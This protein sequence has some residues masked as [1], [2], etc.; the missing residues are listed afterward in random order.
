MQTIKKV[1]SGAIGLF[2]TGA[3]LMGPALA[4]ADLSDFQNMGPSDT[5]IVVGA[6]AATADVVGGINIGGKLAQ[7][8]IESATCSVSCADG[9]TAQVTDGVKIETSSKKLR[10]KGG[11][12]YATL[13]AVRDKLSSNDLD[14]LT[15]TTVT[16]ADGT[17]TTLNQVLDLG[18]KTY[19]TFGEDDPEGSVD[20]PRLILKTDANEP[21][22]EL[23]LTSP[24]GLETKS[25]DNDGPGLAGQDIV[26]AGKTFTVSGSEAD[27]TS[28][29]L[30]LYGGGE[31]KTLVAAGDAISFELDGETHTIRMTSWTGTG[32]IKGVFELDGVSY[33]KGA[34]TAITVDPVTKSKV[35]IKKVEEVKVPSIA[36]GAATEG[37]QATIFVGSSE[38]VIDGTSAPGSVK[39]GDSTISGAEVAFVNSSATKI[40]KIVV[41]YKPDEYKV[42]EAGGVI[43]DPVFGVFD[44]AFAGVSPDLQSD[45]KDKI[46]VEK[47]SNKVRLSFTNRA[48]NSISQDMYLYEG[49]NTWAVK[50][51]SSRVIEYIENP[52]V[53]KTDYF[54]VSDGEYSHVL[55][56]T[57]ID[58]DKDILTIKDIASGDS[59]EVGFTGA[60]GDLYL[61][62]TSYALSGI[63]ESTPYSFVVDD[64][65]IDTC[66]MRTG[67]SV[68][69]FT[70][71]GARIELNDTTVEPAVFI[72]EA[73]DLTDTDKLNLTIYA[74][75]KSTGTDIEDVDVLDKS[76]LIG[77]GMSNVADGKVYHGLTIYGSLV[78][79]DTDADKVTLYYP[80]EQTYANVYVMKAGVSPPTT[81]TT[82]TEVTQTVEVEAPSLGNGIAKLDS[83]VTSVDKEEKNLILVGGPVVNNLVAELAAAQ[84]TPD[85]A[86]WRSDLVGKY[87]LQSVEDAF[88]T[89]KTAIVVAGYEAAD[90]QAASLK[91]A[92]EDVSGAAISCMGT[93]CSDFVY[94]AAEEEAPA[95][96]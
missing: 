69:M 61:G 44:F 86:Y 93:T 94:P 8:G 66:T 68:P 4:A 78:V 45:A 92:T 26:I 70:K 16:Y 37:A 73:D 53:N 13:D 28:T 59:I 18:D 79:S 64:A 46:V 60:T 31:E 77:G 75:Q 14:L 33:T 84:K 12:K 40:S 36:G 50:A 80:D 22:Y 10:L 25:E 20:S 27:I 76:G 30:T 32:T 57:S 62:S 42:A 74:Q 82:G 96:E 49:S 65:C 83:A 11:S 85:T 7:S 34:N 9:G 24:T 39:V 51:T 43:N 90:T 81:T 55:Q 21:L 47:N 1:A 91:L 72:E 5:V 56:Y 58:T 6:S 3:T 67:R 71:R 88:A 15:E 23:T 35:T 52:T 87:I 17:T 38:V 48:G 63:T 89:G 95:E 19:V 2:L 41:T 29:K 54:I